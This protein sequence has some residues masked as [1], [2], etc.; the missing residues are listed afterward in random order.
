MKKRLIVILSI[1]GLLAGF[2][3]PVG[4]G[5]MSSDNYQITTTVMS[6]G[7]GYMGSTN[8][9][10]NATMGQPSPLIY[11]DDPPRSINY[12]LLAG[13]WYTVGTFVGCP[14]DLDFDGD[15]DEDDLELLA[16]DFGQTGDTTDADGDSDM[17]GLDL[18]WMAVDF[19]REDC[20]P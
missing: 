6:G 16:D 17:D 12:D 5:P 13:F 18:Y 8:F 14:A 15:V 2:A 3:M 10:M 11:P 9:Q 20:L 19:D 1:V 7:G 4:A